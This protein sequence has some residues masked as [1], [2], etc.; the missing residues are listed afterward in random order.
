M[1]IETYKE[2]RRN[3]LKTQQHHVWH[4]WIFLSSL[5]SISSLGD[6]KGIFYIIHYIFVFHLVST[7]VPFI[8]VFAFCGFRYPWSY[9]LQKYSMQNSRNKQFI[10]IELHIIQYP[11][12]I[13][14][15]ST[16]SYPGCESYL[17]PPCMTPT[18]LSLSSC[19]CYQ[20]GYQR[21]RKT[22]FT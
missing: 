22:T 20:I 10:S 16:S 19:F 5:L 2:Q 3:H 12:E 13:S 11:D 21:E 1:Y 15:H 6:P 18:H 17:C 14:C 9:M 4:A 7:V 8:H